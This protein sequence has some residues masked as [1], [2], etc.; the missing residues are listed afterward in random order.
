MKI[1]ILD[2]D[3]VEAAPTRIGRCAI[4]LGGGC[5][6]AILDNDLEAIPLG[7]DGIICGDCLEKLFTSRSWSGG[8]VCSE[9]QRQSGRNNARMRG[10]DIH[11][12][13]SLPPKPQPG[14]KTGARMRKR[15]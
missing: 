1:E 10:V 15:L 3:D 12:P 9:A 6:R 8:R 2:D 4:R 13:G 5:G 11:L 14:I 7:K